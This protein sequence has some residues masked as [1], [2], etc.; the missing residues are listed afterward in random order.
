LSPKTAVRIAK[1]FEEYSPF[2]FEEPVAV[3]GLTALAEIRRASLTPIVTGETLYGKEAF[4]SVFAYEAADIVNPDVCACGGILALREIG[5][6]AEAHGVGLAPHNY[7]SMSVALAATLHAAVG[8]ANLVIVEYFVDA[9]SR[10]EEIS[11]GALPV[12]DGFVKLPSTPGLG[13]DLDLEAL[14][15]RSYR[16]FPPRVFVEPANSDGAA[17]T[18][19][20]PPRVLTA[21]Q[22]A[23]AE[24]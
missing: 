10:S 20:L 7:N 22:S 11:G 12:Q 15:R 8:M 21:P 18:N 4:K 3:D 2:W 1:R 16:A 19:L 14:G 24:P 17:S 23:D 9:A 13:I 6:M 5:S